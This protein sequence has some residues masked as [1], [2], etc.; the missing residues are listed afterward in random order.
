MENSTI[1]NKKNLAL[2]KKNE[3][4][5]RQALFND[6]E[7]YFKER[8]PDFR[9]IV[10]RTN[11]EERVRLTIFKK[12]NNPW[13]FDLRKHQL[14]F[15]VQQNKSKTPYINIKIFNFLKSLYYI[16]N[17]QQIEEKIENNKLVKS[18]FPLVDIYLI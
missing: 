17:T 5:F 12:D 18:Y 9:F 15:R 4:E 6:V 10:K 7:V 8:F 3:K 2:I 14:V 11:L 1:S 13:A 16:I